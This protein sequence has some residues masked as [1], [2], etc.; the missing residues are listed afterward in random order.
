MAMKR[1]QSYF[2][3]FLIFIIAQLAWLTLVSLWIYWYVSNYIIFS[4]VGDKLS[5]QIA[6]EGRNVFVLVS[7]LIL[8]VAI[9]VGMSIL[10]RRFSL[11]YNLTNLYDKF[12]ANVTHELKSPLASIQLYLETLKRHDLARDQ[13]QEFIGR[14]LKDAGRL[15][16]L[17]SSIL[18]M[19]A[20]EHKQIAH[21]FE[22]ED[23]D[24]LVRRIV[25][26]A[27]DQFKLP[28]EAIQI[29]GESHA[30]CVVD[31][32][33]MR[34]VLFNLIDNS[35][36]YSHAPLRMTI[37]LSSDAKKISLIIR[38]QGIGIPFYEKN[39]V[40]KKFYRIVTPNSPSV[41]GT[42]LGLYW[43]KEII[44]YHGG[45]ISLMSTE[46]NSGAIFH[47]RLPVYREAR[48]GY[49]AKLLERSQRNKQGEA[50][51]DGAE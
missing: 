18:E 28:S 4:Q 6:E 9:S 1:W 44:Q 13:Q 19:P 30:P 17:I 11:Q 20:L 43:V 29:K 22:I 25:A 34:I 12:I 23:M 36:K 32:E 5:P 40:F 45:S 42:G 37:T 48:R 47:I 33:A 8:L 46:N 27:N 2:Y 41:K 51:D 16:H 49:L 21:R 10:F 50:S 38:D 14:M 39:K 15:D 7:G 31:A 35:I 3:P 26:D 24:A